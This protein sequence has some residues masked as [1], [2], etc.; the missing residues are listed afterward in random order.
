MKGS[1]ASFN[2]TGCKGELHRE[3][4]GCGS[5]AISGCGSG[6]GSK[7]E[8]R[9]KKKRTEYVSER[10]PSFNENVNFPA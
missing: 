1:I 4:G 3:S 8:C 6:S 7:K 2:K 10:L 9:G 5:G